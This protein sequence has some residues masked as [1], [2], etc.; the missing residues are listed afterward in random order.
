MALFSV[1]IRPWYKDVAPE[2]QRY[3]RWLSVKLEGQP[4]TVEDL[5]ECALADPK[6]QPIGLFAPEVLAKLVIFPASQ[7]GPTLNDLLR[8]VAGPALESYLSLDEEGVASGSFLLFEAP[9]RDPPPASPPPAA[10][11]AGSPG[12]WEAAGQA[13]SSA[14][15]AFSGCP[16]W[17]TSQSVPVAGPSPPGIPVKPHKH[18]A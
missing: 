3:Q 17:G 16:S 18:P 12:P 9:L 5:L 13:A 10:S 2:M 11:G 7:K 6:M 8:A 14:E 4:A 1:W 15:C